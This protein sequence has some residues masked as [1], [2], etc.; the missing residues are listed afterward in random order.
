MRRVQINMET[1]RNVRRRAPTISSE[2]NT[3]AFVYSVLKKLTVVS[4]I[5][6]AGYMNWSIAWL[7]T[8]I[9]LTETR[10]YLSDTNIVRRKLAKASA[11]GTERDAL[12]ARVRDLPSWVIAMDPIQ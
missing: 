4:A 8:P 12:L 1:N 2:K 5:Y 11:R 7:I 6:C 10:E 3:S 9:L